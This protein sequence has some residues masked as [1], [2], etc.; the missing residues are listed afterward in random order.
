MTPM[1]TS[2]GFRATSPVGW[3]ERHRSWVITRYADVG[4]ALR[5]PLLTAERISP[6][7]DAI[8]RSSQSA[9]VASTFEIL[10]DWLVFKDPPDHTRRGDSSHEPSP[11]AW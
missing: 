10:A 2:A 4:A 8:N 5:S 9:D 1:A 6:F 3:N 11:R 7:A